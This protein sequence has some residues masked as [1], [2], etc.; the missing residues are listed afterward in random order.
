[1]SQ[2]INLKL[3]ER[4]DAILRLRSQYIPGLQKL[5]LTMGTAQK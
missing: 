1:M 5:T 3:P 2:Y 4:L